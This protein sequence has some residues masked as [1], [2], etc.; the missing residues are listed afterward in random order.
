MKKR[1]TLWIGMLL[2][3]LLAVTVAACSPTQAAP[4][5]VS[6]ETSRYITVVG[7]GEVS[8]SPDIAQ[9][10]VG[11]EASA[12]TVSEAKAEVDR[13]VAA[14]LDALKEMGVAEKDIQTSNYSIYYERE[15]VYPMAVEE[16]SRETQGTYH[17]SNMLNVTIRDLEQVG[18]V[19][20]AVIEAGANQMYGVTFTVSDDQEWESEAREKAMAD[21]RE[22][23]GELASLAEVELGEVLSVSEVVGG[24]AI[25]MPGFAL[26]AEAAGGGIVPGELEL[27]TQIQVTFAI[28]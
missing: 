27:S 21:A 3:G 28:K 13:R 17:V 18:D 22:R 15:P 24:G 10:N 19:L 8:L 9:I 25:P 16:T 4:A 6:Q 20:D 23:A 2:V 11:A 7:V 14:I 1:H 12:D 5:V 26:A